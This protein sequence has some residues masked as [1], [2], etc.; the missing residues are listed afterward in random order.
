MV[1]IVMT[2]RQNVR[3]Q[4][5]LTAWQKVYAMMKAKLISFNSVTCFYYAGDLEN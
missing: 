4:L 3:L 1:I 2:K 5:K